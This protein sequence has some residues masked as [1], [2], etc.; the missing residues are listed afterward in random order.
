M[1]RGIPSGALRH[2]LTFETLVVDLD[3]DGEQVESW[4]PAF[5]VNSRLPAE[6][7]ALSGRELIAAQAVQSKVSTRIRVSYRP[8]FAPRMRATLGPTI[9]NIEAVIPD[10]DSRVRFV[11]LLCSSGVNEG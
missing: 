10:P 1:S 8:G 7:V 4:A 11:T 9:F 5:A 2:W 6:V 3:S